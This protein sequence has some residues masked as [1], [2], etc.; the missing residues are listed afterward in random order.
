MSDIFDAARDEARQQIS[1]EQDALT[2]AAKEQQRREQESSD[3]RRR[4]TGLYAQ[5][6]QLHSLLL[7]TDLQPSHSEGEWVKGLRAVAAGSRYPIIAETESGRRGWPLASV[8]LEGRRRVV[9]AV[10]NNSKTYEWRQQ[11]VGNQGIALLSSGQVH[12]YCCLEKTHVMSI[13]LNIDL[14]ADLPPQFVFDTRLKSHIYGSSGTSVTNPM[15][16]RTA[17]ITGWAAGLEQSMKELARACF[18]ILERRAPRP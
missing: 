1:A 17:V 5:I 12:E 10:F 7:R 6:P 13:G 15:E 4:L 16:R 14:A 11:P 2:A 8:T 18:D 9:T 3:A